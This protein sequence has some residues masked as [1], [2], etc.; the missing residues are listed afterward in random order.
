MARVRPEQLW[1]DKGT[2]FPGPLMARFKKKKQTCKLLRTMGKEQHREKKYL[3]DNARYIP[4]SFQVFD[5]TGTLSPL[6]MLLMMEFEEELA[7]ANKKMPIVIPRKVHTL[8]ETDAERQTEFS[9]E[10][11][12]TMFTDEQARRGVSQATAIGRAFSPPEQGEIRRESTAIKSDNQIGYLSLVTK[13]A[14]G[15]ARLEIQRA[16]NET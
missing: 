2:S 11:R 16:E 10:L 14:H 9:Q 5:E 12:R 3:I 6:L 15:H 13:A 4:E 8:L 7:L 1:C